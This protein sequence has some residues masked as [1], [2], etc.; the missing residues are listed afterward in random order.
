MEIRQVSKS[1][2]AVHGSSDP[3]QCQNV[4]ADQEEKTLLLKSPHNSASFFIILTANHP[5]NMSLY[6][7]LSLVFF[8]FGS[9][10]EILTRSM[11]ETS[12]PAPNLLET[13]AAIIP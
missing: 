3:N 4:V 13:L 7:P 8:C 12:V 1:Q 9:K 2:S 6:S 11:T 5:F 10:M